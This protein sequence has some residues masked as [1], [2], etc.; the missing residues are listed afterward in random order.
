MVIGARAEHVFDRRNAVTIGCTI[1]I[2]AWFLLTFVARSE[3]ALMKSAG[4]Y[5]GLR[6]LCFGFVQLLLKFGAAGEFGDELFQDFQRLGVFCPR[7]L[8]P[9]GVDE[10]AA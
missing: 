5:S 7:F 8:Q 6:L 9:V 4:F 1:R 3:C 2:G 10:H